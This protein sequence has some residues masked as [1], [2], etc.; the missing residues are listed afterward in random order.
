MALADKIPAIIKHIRKYESTLEY[1]YRVY[2]ANEGQIKKEIQESMAR[3]IISPAALNRAL[4]RIPSI[5]ILKKANDKISTVYAEPVKRLTKGKTDTDII[6]N[7]VKIGNLDMAMMNADAMANLC[8]RSA[9]EPYVDNGKQAFRV[10]AAHQFLP[11]GDDPLN[12]MKMTV[13]IKMMGKM[14][15]HEDIGDQVNADS[16]IK[17]GSAQNEIREVST[18]LLYSDDEVLLIDQNGKILSE[19]QRELGISRV[20]EFGVIP[21]V[22]INKSYFELVPF[23]DTSGLDTA[24]L[25][26]KLLTDLNY[27]VQ[28]QSHSIIWMK[29]VNIG[30]QEINPDTVIDLGERVEGGGE[31]DIGVIQPKVDIAGV[32][33]MVEFELNGY[34]SSIGIKVQG[35][36]A[37]QSGR[38]ISGIAKAIDEGDVTLVRRK[39]IEGFKIVEAE[40]WRKMAIIQNVWSSMNLLDKES[41]KFSGDMYEGFT[42]VFGETK[43]I[44]SIESK[45]RKV[46]AQNKLGI[47]TKRDMIKEFNPDFTKPQ[48]EER[49]AAVEKEQEEAMAKMMEEMNAAA[50]S[51]DDNNPNGVQPN[52]ASANSPDDSGEDK[53]KD[54]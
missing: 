9:I 35:L 42:V 3:E 49:M 51:S 17:A 34:L 28:F 11:F 14:Y 5:N 7:I 44:E 8:K 26:P 4:Q 24:I 32:L 33:Q 13:F 6:N 10:Y 25:I 53:D 2:V 52:A 50:A 19:K 37:L 46:E 54:A 15:I 31:P 22:Y 23:P 29:N 36:N 45:V 30:N 38:E 18:Y 12:K 1:N 41:R 27:A 40:L 47:I 20:N 21:Q 16:G 43:V 39:N 48:I